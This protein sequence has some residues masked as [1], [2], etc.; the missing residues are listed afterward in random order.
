VTITAYDLR[1][2]IAAQERRTHL[3]S[4]PSLVALAFLHLLFVEKRIV[5]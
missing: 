2:D 1:S 5:D 3:A 4:D